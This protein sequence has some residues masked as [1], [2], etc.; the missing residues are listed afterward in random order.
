L[1]EGP[2]KRITLATLFAPH[3]PSPTRVLSLS[4]S[5]SLSLCVLPRLDIISR[6]P[7]APPRPLRDDLSAEGANR[8]VRWNTNSGSRI[9]RFLISGARALRSAVARALGSAG[10]HRDVPGFTFHPARSIFCF[11]CFRS[12]LPLFV[13]IVFSALSTERANLL[14]HN[15]SQRG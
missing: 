3:H 5:L 15:K 4:L 9:Y 6:L 1:L 13:L 12:L 11:S 2:K 14:W 10:R 7:P 8:R